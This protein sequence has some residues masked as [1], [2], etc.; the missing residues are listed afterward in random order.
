MAHNSVFWRTLRE[1]FEGLGSAA[2]LESGSDG[3]FQSGKFGLVG[4]SVLP[5]CGDGKRPKCHWTIWHFPNE[6]LKARLCTFALRAAK[7]LG[8]DSEDA[9]FDRLRE[10]DFV[11]FRT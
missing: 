8:E 1:D 9:W 10:A 5:Q 2:R 7:E 3:G 4:T 11:K 6:S